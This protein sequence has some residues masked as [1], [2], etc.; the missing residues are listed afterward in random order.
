V[1]AV[2]NEAIAETKRKLPAPGN[3]LEGLL[4]SQGE[5]YYRTKRVRKIVA[6]T[7]KQTGLSD[8]IEKLAYQAAVAE[9]FKGGNC[10]E[11][12]SV[13]FF[14]LYKKGGLL[15]D[16]RVIGGGA[17]QH[18]IVNDPMLTGQ[19]VGNW[20]AA[21]A[22]YDD[23]FAVLY[24]HFAWPGGKR[25]I[26]PILAD[27]TDL[28]KPKMDYLEQVIAEHRGEDKKDTK[29]GKLVAESYQYATGLEPKQVAED[30]FESPSTWWDKAPTSKDIKE[31]TK[32]FIQKGVGLF[33]R[34]LDKQA[35][36]D[37]VL[38]KSRNEFKENEKAKLD[39]WINERKPLL[40]QRLSKELLRQWEISIR[41][42]WLLGRDSVVAKRW[43]RLRGEIVSETD[44]LVS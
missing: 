7:L 33:S 37:E 16:Y 14:E 10:G 38:A 36:R 32:S 11:F 40:G 43:R 31:R 3:T 23:A 1:F 22:W 2:V 20:V 18:V 27:G 21:D 34:P 41:E 44:H 5:S 12:A 19:G 42:P 13:L 25:A 35:L 24:K 30:F 26:G 8:P 29:L 4:R 39:E 28:V 15:L 17:H 9:K 6:K